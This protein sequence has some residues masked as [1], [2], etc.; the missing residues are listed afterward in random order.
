MAMKKIQK[1]LFTG[2]K[3]I[4]QHPRM[5]S[6]I[7]IYSEYK[8]ENPENIKQKKSFRFSLVSK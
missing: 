8:K 4:F 6:T 5:R 1:I 3:I 7:V 2:V